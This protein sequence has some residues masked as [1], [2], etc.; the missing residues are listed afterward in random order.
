MKNYFKIS[1][2][3]LASTILFTSCVKEK[4]AIKYDEA[5]LARPIVEMPNSPTNKIG[6]ASVDGTSTFAEIELD[7]L[8][9]AP[10]SIFSGDVGVV[11]KQDAAVV[12]QFINA[13][14][15]PLPVIA[16][17]PTSAWNIV[18]TNYTLNAG[19]KTEKVKIRVNTT[20]IPAGRVAIGVTIQSAAGAEVSGLYK[21]I[22]VELKAKS[23]Y[24][25]NYVATGTRTSYV[26]ATVASGVAGTSTIS[27]TKYLST[28]DVST[29]D[30]FMGDLAFVP[31]YFSLKVNAINN[32]VTVLASIANPSD[33]PGTVGN[34]GVCTYNTTSKT[35]TL[36]YFYFNGAGNLRQLTETLVRQ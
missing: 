31:F 23:P 24:E 4:Y 13:Q 2:A 29:V 28:V 20:L 8:R 9:I 14:P 18:K 6:T 32:N 35:F 30:G 25:A 1:A 3:I 34:N 36:N 26:G 16:V 33:T 12:T 5:N 19:N 22:V 27:G 21:S 11:L 17:L 15:T 10:R 7:E